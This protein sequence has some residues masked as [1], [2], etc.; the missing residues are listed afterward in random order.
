MA[1]AAE[2]AGRLQ[3]RDLDVGIVDAEP[4]AFGDVVL[5]RKDTPTSYHLAV[6]VD[7]HLQGV[8]TVT[9]GADLFAATDVHC[10]LQALLGLKRPDYRHHRLLTNADGK[11]FAKRDGDLT[12]GGLRAAG[13]TPAEVRELTGWEGAP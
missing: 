4:A 5:A 3:W 10:L 9:R 1:K 7:D 12:I 13:R 11:R 2:A 8:T 6:T